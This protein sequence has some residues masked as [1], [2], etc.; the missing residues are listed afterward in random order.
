MRS[1]ERLPEPARL[2]TADVIAE[3]DWLR[4]NGAPAWSWANRLETTDAALE[5]TLR[6]AGRN[7]LAN[8][9]SHERK[10]AA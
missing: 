7:D 2:D 8:Q 4:R 9:M 10:A 3:V 5:Q 1:H 6:R